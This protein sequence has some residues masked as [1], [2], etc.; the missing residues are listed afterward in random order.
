MSQAA[1]PIGHRNV[2]LALTT[3]DDWKIKV[4]ASDVEG[5]VGRK[6]IMNTLTGV[7][8]LGRGKQKE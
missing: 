4:V 5:T 1:Y 7:V 8:L 2:E 6:I 3:L